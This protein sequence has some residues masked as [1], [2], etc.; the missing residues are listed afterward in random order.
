MADVTME[1]SVGDEEGGSESASP[2]KEAQDDS[3]AAGTSKD[4][5]NDAAN[6]TADDEADQSK[7]ND[8]VADSKRRG[9]KRK[10]DI[11]QDE[12]YVPDPTKRGN[13]YFA[14]CPSAL[15]YYLLVC[16]LSLCVRVQ[17][18]WLMV[19]RSDDATP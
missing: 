10:A 1:D 6:T 11:P 12:K 9:R 4:S 13:T 15:K 5:E 18:L 19:D 17:V 8:D 14:S 2:T 16:F 3:E 7:S